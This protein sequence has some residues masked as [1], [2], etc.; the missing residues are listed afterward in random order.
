MNL[1]EQKKQMALEGYYSVTD[2]ANLKGKSRQ[3]WFKKHKEGKIESIERF[4]RVWLKYD[5][6]EN[7]KKLYPITEKPKL[8]ILKEYGFQERSKSFFIG[9][10]TLIDIK[11][12]NDKGEIAIAFNKRDTDKT[13]YFFSNINQFEII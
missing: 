1:K 11:L 12:L 7:G 5:N 10:D 8:D 3:L 9:T 6:G 2:Y 13:I 4:D